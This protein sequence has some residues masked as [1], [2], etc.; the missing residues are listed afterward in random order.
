MKG[1]IIMKRILLL[2]LAFAMLLCLTSC[3]AVKGF[4][5]GTVDGN[6]YTQESFGVTFTA[7]AG[8]TF[9]SDEEIASLHN[10][11]VEELEA[12]AAVIYDVRCG[13]H[14]T[15]GSVNINYEELGSVYGSLVDEENYIA[16]SL[17]NV[18]NMLEGMDGISIIGAEKG[19]VEISGDEYNGAYITLNINGTV[20]YETVFVKEKDGYMMACTAAAHTQEEINSVMAAITLK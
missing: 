18:E 13:N 16:L 20:F 8:Y 17:E 12:N 10:T 15:G 7:P 2:I 5:R 14:S 1:Y 3:S 11:T 9:Y 6:T 19:M 4:E